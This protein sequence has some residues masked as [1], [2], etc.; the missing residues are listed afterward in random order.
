MALSN[1]KDTQSSQTTALSTASTSTGDDRPMEIPKHGTSWI[2]VVVMITAALGSFL[3]GFS[4][5]AIA[6]TLAQ[7]TFITKFLQTEATS[8]TDG[9]LGGFLGGALVGAIA[10][11]PLSNRH[12][13]RIA[14]GSASVII[15]VSGALQAGSVD[16]AMLLTARVLCG[17]GAGMVFTNTPVYMSE[18]SPPHTRGLLVGFQ[19]VGVTSAYISCALFG[20]IFNFVTSEIQWRLIFI[21][22]AA[23][24]VIHLFS[25]RFIPE[26]PRWLMEQGREEEAR[27]VLEYLHR[28]KADPSGTLAQAEIVQIKAQVEA[29]R[30]LPTGY[31]HILCTSHLRK[32]AFCSI[33][34]W[35]MGQGTG[36]TAIANLIPVL[37][38][39]LGFG[40]VMQLGLGVAWTV[41]AVIG[42]GFNVLLADRVGR[43]R[44]LVVGGF[45]CAAIISI[46]A[47][48]EKFYLQSTYEPGVNAAVALYF[49]FGAFFTSTIECTSYVYTTEI[50]PT[51][52]RSEG[53]TLA[54]A[55]FFGNAIA[56][57]APV[58]FGLST[59]GW[60]F[61]M[62]FV[63]VTTVSTITIMLTF[64]ET[65]GLTLEEI[66]SRFGDKVEIDLQTA[67]AAG[68]EKEHKP[69]RVTGV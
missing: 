54:F 3:Y 57:S 39:S 62:V 32:R 50:W 64:P 22:L 59:I 28:T 55:S 44:L 45:G 66:N 2:N 38:G 12:G 65:S 42:C 48:L 11:A 30:A 20:L 13:R 4:A 53:S 43:V 37:M 49:I 17:I 18:V 8:R 15:I 31:W 16:I 27:T 1:M 51:H 46:L 25:L 29:E 19:G 14:N 68:L 60:K 34:L 47:A 26:S 33:M 9:L 5:N 40:T 58:S 56:Y 10:Q 67:L 21:V 63:A 7:P 6:S 36:I 41:C 23:I 69:E 35:V 52:L 24:G 61:Y